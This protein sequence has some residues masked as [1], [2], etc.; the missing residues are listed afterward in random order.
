M[1]IRGKLID[2]LTGHSIDTQQ[3]VEYVADYLIANG[4]TVQENVKMSDELL[5]QLKNAPITTWKE[6]PSIETVQEWIS[7]KDRLPEAGGYVVCIAKRNPFSRFMPMVARIEKNGWVNPMTEQY[8]SEVTH[9]M[10]MPNPPKG[11]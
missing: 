1:D 4:V 2:L 8:I 5:K 11:E 10:P 6:E 7:V 9:W 3:D